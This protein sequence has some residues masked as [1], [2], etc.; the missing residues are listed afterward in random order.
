MAAGHLRAYF[1]QPLELSRYLAAE[2]LVLNSGLSGEQRAKVVV[3][4]AKA[5]IAGRDAL[6]AD[7]GNGSNGDPGDSRP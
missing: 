7:T 4:I 3:E 5:M 2:R 1:D 6:N